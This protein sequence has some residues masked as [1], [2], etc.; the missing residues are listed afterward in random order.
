M[1]N[2]AR[3]SFQEQ[4]IQIQRVEK[5]HQVFPSVVGQLKLLEFTVDDGSTFP[6]R[7]RLGDW[8]QA[9]TWR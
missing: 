4:Y 6:V 2:S 9:G 5:E 8:R 7:G 3:G 1:L